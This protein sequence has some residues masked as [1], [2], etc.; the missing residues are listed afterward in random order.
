MDNT[1]LGKSGHETG[2]A[3]PIGIFAGVLS[4][5]VCVYRLSGNKIQA[6]CLES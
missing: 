5:G 2:L 3:D 4:S 6:F 1:D